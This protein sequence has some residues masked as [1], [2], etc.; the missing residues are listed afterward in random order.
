MVWLFYLVFIYI[1][2]IPTIEGE[3]F[4]IRKERV[5][6]KHWIAS[7]SSVYIEWIVLHVIQHKL[8][9]VV[10]MVWTVLIVFVS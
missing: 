5:Y 1:T 10:R 9:R 4:K 2:R 7:E 3:D 8:Y 6:S